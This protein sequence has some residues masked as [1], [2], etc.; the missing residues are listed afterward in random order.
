MHYIDDKGHKSELRSSR[1]NLSNP[2]KSKSC[3]LLFMVSGVE[4]VD[5]H[6]HICMKVIS[7]QMI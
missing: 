2:T 7:P 5:T 6:I 1:N 3:H 4:S